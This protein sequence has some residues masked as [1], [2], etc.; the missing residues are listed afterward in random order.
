MRFL[1]AGHPRGGTLWMAGVMRRL[2]Y[3]VGHELAIRNTYQPDLMLDGEVSWAVAM[4]ELPA[5]WPV[6]HIVRHPLDVIRSMYANRSPWDQLGKLAEQP[7]FDVIVDSDPLRQAVKFWIGWEAACGHLATRHPYMMT[8]IETLTVNG[9]RQIE[10]H[11]TGYESENYEYEWALDL[12]TN[13]NSTLER[14]MSEQPY[15]PWPALLP[16]RVVAE[17]ISGWPEGQTVL[18]AAQQLG[19]NKDD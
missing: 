8:R 19:Y 18:E 13:Y 16:R 5:D 11:L 2:G 12:R 15:G 4:H 17:R 7:P 6:L 1:V 14:Q 10:A 9:L 3:Q